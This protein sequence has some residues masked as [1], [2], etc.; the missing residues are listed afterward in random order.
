MKRSIILVSLLALAAVAAIGATT[1][2][3]AKTWEF[4]G[5]YV[6]ACSCDLFCSCYFHGNPSDGHA[7][8]FDNA[9]TMEKGSHYGALDLAGAKFWMSGDL[10]ADFKNGNA[11]WGHLTWDPSVTAP[12]RDA[13]KKMLGKVYPVKWGEMT[14]SESGI[15]FTRTAKM[16]SAKTADGS[17]HVEL[18]FIPASKPGN[19]VVLAN[20]QYWGSSGNEGFVLAF[21]KHGYKGVDENHSYDFQDN[22]N[23]FTIKVRAHGAVTE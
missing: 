21:S 13:I 16:V 9:V 12:Q 22:R 7:C 10:G 1:A 6:E 11:T 23:G 15:E 2:D 18:T 8:K 3:R 17:A 5:D 14:E 4:R 20:Q 19:H